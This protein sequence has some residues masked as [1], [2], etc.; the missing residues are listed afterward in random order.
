VTP[1]TQSGD[2][3][4]GF[5]ALEMILS[6]HG[7]TDARRRLRAAIGYPVAEM[8]AQDL[9]VALRRCGFDAQAFSVDVAQLALLPLPAVLHWRTGHFVVLEVAGSK[10]FRII[11]PGNGSRRGISVKTLS[12]NFS[13]AAIACD[14]MVPPVNA[15]L[16]TVRAPID[17]RLF[18]AAALLAVSCLIEAGC[19]L[20][21]VRAASAAIRSAFNAGHLFPFAWAA[22]VLGVSVALAHFAA[23]SSAS[24]LS[25]IV[26]TTSLRR[27]RHAIPLVPSAFLAGR[28]AEFIE[29]ILRAIDTTAASAPRPDAMLRG[30][31]AVAIAGTTLHLGVASASVVMSAAIAVA[32][33]S[34]KIPP[35]AGVS[36]ARSASGVALHRLVRRSIDLCSRGALASELDRWAETYQHS[37]RQS[38]G[39]GARVAIAI[40]AGTAALVPLSTVLWHGASPTW[41]MPDHRIAA[42]V[43]TVIVSYWYLQGLLNVRRVARWQLYRRQLSVLIEEAIVPPEECPLPADIVA[44]DQYPLL[45]CRFGLAESAASSPR[46]FELVVENQK[47]VAIVFQFNDDEAR[48]SIARTLAGAVAT[49]SGAIK[50]LGRSLGDLL[51]DERRRIVAAVLDD[52]EP[53]EGS[54][55]HNLRLGDILPRSASIVD[56]CDLLGISAYTP[57]WQRPDAMIHEAMPLSE[58]QRKL[59]CLANVLIAP[60]R[61]L[62]LDGIMDRFDVS[63]A[64]LVVNAAASRATVILFTGREDLIPSH[65]R[66]CAWKPVE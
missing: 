41:G 40:V 64:Q 32:I 42:A 62:I 38:M 52:A 59:I 1:V 63:T 44:V 18:G 55:E 26:R 11:D 48:T 58:R 45:Q 19:L 31:I 2:C 37:Q 7:V 29:D 17:R 56:A 43:L 53:V 20:T 14:P 25:S 16:R 4:C 22:V 49:P 5:A 57:L 21:F 24:T 66:V 28:R 54:L 23:R 47:H 36:N 61:L 33:V 30:L 9:V 39:V 35:A 34:W 60:P 3:D 27:L 8:T 51:P 46:T 6:V 65:F 15:P 50:V 12:A 10:A 13:G